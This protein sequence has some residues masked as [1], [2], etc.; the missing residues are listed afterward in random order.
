VAQALAKDKTEQPADPEMRSAD[1]SGDTRDDKRRVVADAW[2]AWQCQMVAGVLRGAVF[3]TSDGQLQTLLANWPATDNRASALGI[4]ATRAL[5]SGDVLI[6]PSQ[7]SSDANNQVQDHIAIPV[8]NEGGEFIVVMHIISRSQSQQQAVVQLVQWGGMWLGSLHTVVGDISGTASTVSVALAEQVLSHNDLYAASLEAANR[9][10][11]ELQ[12]NRVSVG[13]KTGAAIQLQAISQIVKFDQRRALVRALEAAMEEAVDQQSIINIADTDSAQLLL[14]RAH[15]ELQSTHG[16]MVACTIPL[17]SNGEA[18]GAV[19]LERDAE[20]GFPS[21][22]VNRAANA[23]APMGPILQLIKTEQRSPLLRLRDWCKRTFKLSNLPTTIK[24]RVIAGLGSVL[25]LGI[26]FV[27]VPYNVSAQASIEGSDKQVLVAPHAGY[28]KSAHARAG[29]RVKAGQLIASLEDRELMIEKQRWL[30]E[31]GKLE[32][33]LARALSVRD[34]SELGMVQAKKAQVDAE[35]ALIEQKLTRSKLTAPFDGVLVSGDLNQALGAPVEVGQV[36]FEVASMES[37]RL[38]L[39]VEEHDVAGI[40]PNQKGVLRFSALP[41]NKHKIRT[42][43]VIPVALTRERKSVFSIEA[44][45]DEQTDK[46][47]PGMRGVAK[48]RVGDKPLIMNW[49]H[50]LVAKMRLWFWKAGL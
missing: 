7:K 12:C 45:L 26:L 13:L 35:L 41:G 24:G 37:Y 32:T 4:F 1:S 42:N 22:A 2:L 15:L 39:E 38:V 3:S 16:S 21:D 36:L 43:S 31:L 50:T 25:V 33:S 10:C 19:L 20:Q 23:L 40:G 6:N 17:Y 47:R 11:S 18:V 29:D 48:I 34:R 30:G 8:S 5:E 28:I 44:E 27:P 49:T 46:L 9:L 14:T